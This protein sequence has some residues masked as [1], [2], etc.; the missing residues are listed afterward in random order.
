MGDT[1]TLEIRDLS[2]HNAG[3]YMCRA[4]NSL[5]S[6]DAVAHLQVNEK[7]MIWNVKLYIS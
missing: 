6:V 5:D 2:S 1:G 4:E 7:L 3:T